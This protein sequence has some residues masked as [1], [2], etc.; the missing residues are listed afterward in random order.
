MV[1]EYKIEC[2]RTGTRR[3]AF[4]R[5]RNRKI[6]TIFAMLV[7]STILLSNRMMAYARE[8]PSPY[9]PTGYH[10]FSKHNLQENGGTFIWYHEVY[11]GERSG[12]T[13]YKK[14]EVTDKSRWC[15]PSCSFCDRPSPAGR[16]TH[17]EITYSLGCNR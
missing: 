6:K 12:V 14:C 17:S 5:K 16:H 1:K 10:D 11:A 4:M 3:R 9:S 2:N 7:V 13:V 15:E 8:C